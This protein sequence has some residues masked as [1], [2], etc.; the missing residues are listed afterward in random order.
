MRYGSTISK[1]PTC[2]EPE[3]RQE[4]ERLLSWIDATT[5]AR[6]GGKI[7]ASALDALVCDDPRLDGRE[8][9]RAFQRDIAY[10]VAYLGLPPP[11]D[12]FMF[13]D[14]FHELAEHLVVSHVR[15]SGASAV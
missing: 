15:S 1:R 10:V 14:E 12:I 5:D 3:Y 13:P 4:R 6:W 2:G 8:K 9:Q 11:A 7:P